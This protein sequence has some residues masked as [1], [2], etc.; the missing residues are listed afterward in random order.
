MSSFWFVSS[1][2]SSIFVTFVVRSSTLKKKGLKLNCKLYHRKISL[3]VE[4]FAYYCYF[5]SIYLLTQTYEDKYFRCTPLRKLIKRYLLYGLK[6]C[7]KILWS[8][9]RKILI[10]WSKY[11]NRSLT[12]EVRSWKKLKKAFTRKLICLAG[13][14]RVPC[15]KNIA[16]V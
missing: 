2:L 3:R 7:E 8:Q 5:V 14:F 12:S 10:T 4:N 9:S 15:L 11:S 13:F 6:F 1:R 16:S